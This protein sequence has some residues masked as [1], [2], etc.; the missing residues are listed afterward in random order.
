[1]R[2]HPTEQWA[3]FLDYKRT[4]AQQVAFFANT[5][6]AV[7]VSGSGGANT[8]WMKPNT[9]YIEI[10]AK[11]CVGALI[12]VA[13]AVGVKVFMTGTYQKN[14]IIVDVPRMLSIIEC[15]FEFLRVTPAGR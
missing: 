7:M 15:G 8:V 10:E 3:L 4:L 13:R 14:W 11:N 6:L 12:D 1:V 5:R 2:A 9:V